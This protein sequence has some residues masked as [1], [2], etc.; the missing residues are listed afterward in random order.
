MDLE[1][2]QIS[3]NDMPSIQNNRQ[4]KERREQLEL[5]YKSLC[6]LPLN[7]LGSLHDTTSDSCW[8]GKK[9]V[10]K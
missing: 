2:T 7:Y 5:Q 6:K 8:A 10:R 4:A 3:K 9:R 1:S